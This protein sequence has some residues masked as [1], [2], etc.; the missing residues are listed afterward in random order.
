M[1]WDGGWRG[2]E[3]HSN[4]ACGCGTL[5]QWEAHHVINQSGAK[6]ATRCRW[7]SV[8]YTCIFLAKILKLAA[9]ESGYTSIQV[10]VSCAY[11]INRWCKLCLCTSLYLRYVHTILNLKNQELGKMEWTEAS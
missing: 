2:F 9:A 10:V 8:Q 4:S 5:L 1:R 7:Y 11:P 3:C 6:S